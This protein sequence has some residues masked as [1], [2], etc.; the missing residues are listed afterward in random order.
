MSAK[1]QRKPEVNNALDE[2][3]SRHPSTALHDDGAIGGGGFAIDKAAAAL[4][5]SSSCR[6]SQ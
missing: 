4:A 5:G 6:K 3:V 1:I 2:P